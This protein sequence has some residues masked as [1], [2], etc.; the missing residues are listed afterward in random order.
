MRARRATAAATILATL[1]ALATGCGGDD[2]T[3]DAARVGCRVHAFNRLRAEIAIRYYDRG[4]LGTRRQIER[5]LG[6]NASFF[7]ANS[8]II[9]YD[10]ESVYQQTSMN[11]WVFSPA[12][13]RVAGKEME[14]AAEEFEPDC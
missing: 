5:R 10:R 11:K 4:L 2:R 14:R 12:V 7:D 8:R 9:P 13:Q 3:A 1:A 6:N